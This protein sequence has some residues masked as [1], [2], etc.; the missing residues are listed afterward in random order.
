M[1]GLIIKVTM[2]D[3]HPP[4]WRRIVVP[5]GI[6][7]HDLHNILQIA[8]GWT[9]THLH[10]FTTPDRRLTISNKDIEND[11]LWSYST[12]DENEVLVDDVL[13]KYKWIRYTYDF[14]DDWCHKIVPE[15]TDPNYKNRFAK[16]LK[17]KGDNFAEDSGG[18]YGQ[19]LYNDDLDN[20]DG[21]DDED[22]FEFMESIRIPFDLEAA[23]EHLEIH[24]IPKR[25]RKRKSLKQDDDYAIEKLEETLQKFMHVSDILKTLKEVEKTQPVQPKTPSQ[26]SKLVERWNSFCDSVIN[27][28]TGLL[29]ENTVSVLR[30]SDKSS[31]G[32]V[33]GLLNTKEI[34]DYLKYLRISTSNSSKKTGI[35]LIKNELLQHPEYGLYIIDEKSLSSLTHLYQQKPGPITQT[36]DSTVIIKAVSIGLAECIFI[37]KYT[38][39]IA[40]TDF[41]D[42]FFAYTRSNSGQVKKTYQILN[43]TLSQILPFTQVYGAIEIDT[44]YDFICKNFKIKLTL[45]EFERIVYWHG[46][47]CMHLNTMT[48]A[49]TGKAAVA[50][51]QPKLSENMMIRELDLQ[52]LPYKKLEPDEIKALQKGFNAVYLSW[53]ELLMF[54]E[55]GCGIEPHKLPDIMEELSLQVHGGIDLPAFA[56]LLL[57]YYHPKDIN[58]YIVL[59][60]ISQWILTETP[61][62]A[63]KGYSR[64]DFRYLGRKL[65][66]QLRLRITDDK[67]S[68]T[69][70]THLYEM[71]NDIQ[72]KLTQAEI[73]DPETKLTMLKEVCCGSNAK[74]EEIQVM[75]I[76][77]HME[78]GKFQEARNLANKLLKT[79]SK[80]NKEAI[81]NLIHQIDIMQDTDD[82]TLFDEP[83]SGDVFDPYWFES[84]M[85]EEKIVPF[86]RES[87]KIGRNDPCPCGSGRKYK[88]CCGKNKS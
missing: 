82:D 53:N 63:L 7:F 3:T 36:L 32:K 35:D 72:E 38:C 33:L 62:T 86:H 47:M 4:M 57:K 83:L 31:F 45:Q 12:E 17:A 22:D 40:F 55:Y 24:T 26:M 21:F 54:L 37:D 13:S 43:K 34:T 65:P 39:E 25:K 70:T 78:Y 61:L 71:S 8:F 80:N 1:S 11:T 28:Q 30:S 29:P 84:E 85:P 58:G 51:S 23:N 2:E 48:F 87:K 77:A 15:K 14:G 50:I 52:D 81:K 10:D 49:I 41:A 76:Q 9:D 68:I 6:N 74:N 20:E 67:P 64:N 75:L 27:Y 73:S 88:H 66:E 16:I 18:V 44:L 69:P 19:M 42:T 60:S 46:R 59:W 5:D 79:I 56:E